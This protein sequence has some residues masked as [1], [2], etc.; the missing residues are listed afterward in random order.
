M[1][2]INSSLAVDSFKSNPFL[3]RFQEITFINITQEVSHE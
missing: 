1:Q 2:S 3:V